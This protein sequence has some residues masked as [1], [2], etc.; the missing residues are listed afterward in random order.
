MSKTTAPYVAATILNN[1]I[2]QYDI[3]NTIL[4]DNCPQSIAKLF[5]TVCHILGIRQKKATLISPTE[6]WKGREIL[7]DNCGKTD[8]LCVRASVK[9]GLVRPVINLRVHRASTSLDGYDTLQYDDHSTSTMPNHGR[10]LKYIA[11]GHV[12][13]VNQQND[14]SVNIKTLKPY[15]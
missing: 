9:L 11:A 6:K 1:W 3:R 10:N 8:T 14:A 4:S 15:V 12:Y 2:S 7:Q 13:L 5:K